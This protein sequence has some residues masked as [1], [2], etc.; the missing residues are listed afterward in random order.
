LRYIRIFRG[1]APRKPDP[2]FHF[3]VIQNAIHE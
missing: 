1:L 2:P 3:S